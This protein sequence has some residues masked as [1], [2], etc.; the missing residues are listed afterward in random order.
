MV[1]QIS[2]SQIQ[3]HQF[4]P[5]ELR[6]TFFSDLIQLSHRIA[7]LSRRLTGRPPIPRYKTD[8]SHQPQIARVPPPSSGLQHPRTR[9]CRSPET[10]TNDHRTLIPRLLH[11]HRFSA[12]K[13]PHVLRLSAPRLFR[14]RRASTRPNLKPSV[15]TLTPT[16][17]T[18][19]S[20]FLRLSVLTNQP[21][22]SATRLFSSHRPSAPAPSQGG[23]A[24]MKF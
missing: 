4:A 8:P 7:S 24:W 3:T 21:I 17:T 20:S 9:T 11:D 1:S 2:F 16:L 23:W 13:I 15:P 5:T 14:V 19:I 10:P 22:P 18:K 12:P 6:N